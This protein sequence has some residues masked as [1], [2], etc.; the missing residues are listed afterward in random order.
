[1]ITR[2][3]GEIRE[4]QNPIPTVIHRTVLARRI[5]TFEDPDLQGNSDLEE[6]VFG[7]GS[8]WHGSVVS[9]RW[10]CGPGSHGST[11]PLGLSDGRSRAAKFETSLS[12]PQDG[13]NPMKKKKRGRRTSMLLGAVDQVP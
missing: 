8:T 12:S 3:I 11:S 10:P 9:T 2:K 5:W 6:N 7:L 4:N 13:S 1:V